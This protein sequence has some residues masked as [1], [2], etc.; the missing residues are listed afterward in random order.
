MGSLRILFL[1]TPAFAAE[2]LRALLAASGM[3]VV[4]V[5]TQPD[6]PRGRGLK[7]APPPVKELALAHG[8]AVRQTADLRGDADLFRWAQVLA[9]DFL[10]VVA[11]GAILPAAW[12]ALPSVAPVNVHAS[13]LPRWRGAA[14]IE[15]ALLAGDQETGV[16]VMKMVEELDAGPI[17]ACARTPIRADD[18]GETLRARLAEMGA[19]LLVETLPKI[20]AGLAP[21]P[22]EG[23]PTYAAKLKPQDREIA[24]TMQADAVDR[25]VRAFAPSPGA[26]VRY[27]GDWLKVLAGHP[28]AAQ[29]APGEV[30]ALDRAGVLVACAEGAY[31]LRIVQPAGKRAMEADAFARGARLCIGARWPAD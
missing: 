19:R 3:E 8:L 11:F 13:L 15:R 17:Y 25:L 10:V 23:T 14:P 20:A 26:R 24:W 1:G 31:R 18:T 16:C 4:G 29:G 5:I 6:R 28:E 21:R 22:Q 30:L 12:L 2:H 27:R 7:L 9:P